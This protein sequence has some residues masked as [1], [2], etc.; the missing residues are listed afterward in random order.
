MRPLPSEQPERTAGDWGDITPTLVASPPAGQ[1]E[2]R[3]DPLSAA[4]AAEDKANEAL[5][6]VARL[7]DRIEHQ[8]VS[9][10][11]QQTEEAAKRG[12]INRIWFP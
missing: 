4:E 11:E 7:D 8:T 12:H 5:K 6:K 2:K 9:A 10:E 1:D 3:S